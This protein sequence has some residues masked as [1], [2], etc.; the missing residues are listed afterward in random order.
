MNGAISCKCMLPLVIAAAVGMPLTGAATQERESTNVT[1]VVFIGA[2]HNYTFLHPRFSPAHVRALLSKIDPAAL[3]IELTPDWPRNDGLPTWPQEQYAALTWAQS[4]EIPVYAV[5]WATPERRALSPIVRMSEGAALTESGQAFE[6]FKEYYLDMVWWTAS[7]AF[8]DAPN[9]IESHQ[10]NSLAVDGWQDEG[11]AAVRDDRI[12]E[13]IRAVLAQYPGQRVAV[14]FGGGHYLPL[15]RRLESSGN[16]RV[17]PPLRYFP[18]EPERIEAGWHPDDAIVLLG[19]NLDDW[20][21]TAFPQ[22]RNHQRSKELLDRLRRE[23][24]GSVVTRYYDA[25]WRMLLGNLDEA[26][27]LLRGILAEDG[28]TTLPYRA[29]TRW[30]WPPF[31]AFEQKARFYLAVASDLAGDRDAA[32]KEYESLMSLPDDQLVVPAPWPP[33]RRIDLRPYVAS[34]MSTPFQGGILEAYRAHFAMGR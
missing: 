18:L 32:L 9:D 19:T 17:A 28:T 33:G 26:S 13:N 16:I 5:D 25:R 22:S 21:S 15:K 4:A 31:R 34:F 8:G 11:D 6:D 23:R 7:Q 3:C 1:D 24:P 20:R 12:A 14:V 10:R 2:N 30:S 27:Q 29:D